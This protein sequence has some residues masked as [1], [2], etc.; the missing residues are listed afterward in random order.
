M[1]ISKSLIP[2]I[3]GFILISV[4]VSA[5]EKQSKDII[6]QSIEKRVAFIEDFEK[7][8]P[9]KKQTFAAIE[10]K[11][12]LKMTKFAKMPEWVPDDAVSMYYILYDNKGRILKHTEVPVSWFRSGDWYT[13]STHYFDE[14]GK[15]I[16]YEHYE[17]SFN[18]DCADIL[19]IDVL[20]YFDKKSRIIKETLTCKDG[21]YNL[22]D[23]SK[24]DVTREDREQ[25]ISKAKSYKDLIKR[26]TNDIQKY[27]GNSEDE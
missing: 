14:K 17:G 19:R 20:Y 8:H 27:R 4:L 16:K 9:Q 15:T 6:V 12:R 2:I 21:A 3:I 25:N 22:L 11:G 13:S 10:S 23:C 18:S 5:E 24:C 1:K 7:K 26:I